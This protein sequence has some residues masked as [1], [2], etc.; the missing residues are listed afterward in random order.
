MGPALLHGLGV[1][2]GE[3][4]PGGQRQHRKAHHH[5]V[6]VVAVERR[7]GGVE[8]VCTAVDGDGAALALEDAAAGP[9][10]GFHGCNAVALLDTE[11]L[12]VADG[13]GPFAEQAQNHQHGAEVGAVGKVN[14]HTVER[15]FLEHDA[16]IGGAEACTT[17]A[18]NVE[19]H[20]IA[21][22]GV[23]G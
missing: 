11:T 20:G 2:D 21:L 4:Q 7:G 18:Q 15:C 22:Q 10:L 6:V 13:G 17:A 5:T 3:F 1:V 9:K 12:R 8:P 16:C 19:D 23:G 14:V